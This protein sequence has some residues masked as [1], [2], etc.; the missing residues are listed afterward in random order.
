MIMM[1][2]GWTW[3]LLWDISEFTGIGLG[4]FAPYVFGKMIGS[5]PVERVDDKENL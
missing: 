3:G 4:R 2:M 5:K 1:N